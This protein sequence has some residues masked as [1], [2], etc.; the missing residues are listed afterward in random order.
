MGVYG[1]EYFMKL[2]IQEAQKA[3]DAG[4]VPIGAVAVFNGEIVARG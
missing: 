2:A 3:A 1:D 4:E